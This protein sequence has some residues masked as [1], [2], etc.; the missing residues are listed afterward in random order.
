MPHLFSTRAAALA[1]VLVL[2]ACGGGGNGGA[3]PSDPAAATATVKGQVFKGPV[4]GAA[5]CVHAISAGIRGD[6]LAAQAGSGPSVTDGCVVTGAD[7]TY[8]IV[9]P[10]G[11]HADLLVE[12]TGGTYC[13]DES[14]FDGTACA[15]GGTPVSMGSHTLRTVLAA[16]TDGTVDAPVTLLTTAAVQAATA[17]DAAS[18]ATAYGTIAANFAAP[19]DPSTSP[20]AGALTTVLRNLAVYVG[21]STADLGDILSG[22]AAG[23]LVAKNTTFPIGVEL[24]VGTDRKSVHLFTASRDGAALVSTTQLPGIPGSYSRAGTTVTVHMPHHN[25]RTG[26]W[27]PLRFAAGTGGSATSGTYPVTR[28]DED[29]FTVIDTASGAITSGTLYRDPVTTRAVTYSQ[30]DVNGLVTVTLPSHGLEVGD[31]VEL[32]LANGGAAAL[33]S[34]VASVLDGNTFTVTASA[35]APG[36]GQVSIGADYASIDT[37]MHPSGKWLYVTSGYECNGSGRPFCHGGDAITTFRI[38]WQRGTLTPVGAI[39]TGTQLQSARPSSL[40]INR[41]GT[42]LVQKDD[43]LSYVVLWNVAPDTGTL[44]RASNSQTDTTRSGFLTFSPDGRYVHD[45]SVMFEVAGDLLSPPIGLSFAAATGG[46]IA[47][48]VLFVTDVENFLIPYSLAVAA[49]PE[50]LTRMATSAMHSGLSTRNGRVLVTSGP[51]GVKTYL[52]D[53]SARSISA[54][55]PSSGSGELQRDGTNALGSGPTS[56]RS[57][58]LNLAG[59]LAVAS[60][61]TH[62]STPSGYLFAT[63]GADGQLAR[64]EDAS[65]AQ[66]ARAAKFIKQP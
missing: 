35:D 7:G 43:W 44:S 57:V 42:Q 22:I 3:A 37:V 40:A 19:A 48:D 66:Y 12:S 65:I 11:T 55:A 47:E 32:K 56:Y 36:E 50:P 28:I 33:T 1:G 38:D 34:E 62:S 27:I 10:A 26:L 52:F 39:R 23:T 63:V 24:V 45:G 14:S 2:A 21:P 54:A 64:I 41:A 29:T 6:R 4:H 8:S 58:H 16:P 60:Y 51:G 61:R 15:G 30:V 9:L 31:T 25:L 18:F 49:E 53:A 20:S 13:S 46:E 17:P 5:V 59:D